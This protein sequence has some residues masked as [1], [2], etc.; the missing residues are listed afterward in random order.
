MRVA[1]VT[2]LAAGGQPLVLSQKRTCALRHLD[3]DYSG[4]NIYWVLPSVPEQSGGP[5]VAYRLSQLIGRGD[6]LRSEVVLSRDVHN[7]AHRSLR[8]VL[9]CARATPERHVFCVTFGPLVPGQIKQIR[10]TTRSPIV[11]YAQSF[12][13]RQHRA[14][15]GASTLSL[16]GNPSIVASSRYVMALW[17]THAP[18]LRVAHIPPPLHSVFKPGTSGRDIDVLVHTRKQSPYCIDRLLPVLAQSRLKV[19][20]LTTWVG[21]H[22]LAQLLN[23]TKVFLYHTPPFFRL[24]RQTFG[25]GFGLTPLEALACGAHVATN[26]LGGVNDFLDHSNATKLLSRDP[27]EDCQAIARAVA[28]F[29][30]Q[31]ARAANVV[32]AFSEERVR[33]AWLNLLQTWFDSAVAP[34]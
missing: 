28:Q 18:H 12:G 4:L 10:A 20:V 16:P 31:T 22:T 2:G 13:W 15:F 6:T 33:G 27:V 9:D 1:G 24:R 26:S 34:G 5:L 17:N 29:A 3:Q 19:E 7:T 32:Q 21:Q 23:R 30:D 14:W 11:Y 8:Q 25:E